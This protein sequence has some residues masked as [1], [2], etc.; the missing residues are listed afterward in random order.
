MLL[1]FQFYNFRSF[2]EPATLSLM[3]K[4]SDKELLDNVMAPELPGISKQRFLRAAAV[5][6]ANAAGKSNIIRS[7]FVLV[8]MIRHSHLEELGKE[9]PHDPF[10]LDSE[11]KEQ[12]TGYRVRFVSEGVRYHYDLIHDLERVLEE[13]LSAFPK[14]SEQ[15]WLDRYWD[16]ESKRYHYEETPESSPI[17]L[18]DKALKGIKGNTLYM[19]YVAN[20]QFQEAIEPVYT[21][22]RDVVDVKNLAE[23]SYTYLRMNDTIRYA[24]NNHHEK[25]EELLKRADFGVKSLVLDQ[26]DLSDEELNRYPEEDDPSKGVRKMVELELT[27]GSTNGEEVLFEMKNESTGTLRMLSLAG[28]W[29]EMIERGKV[30]FLDELETSLHPLLVR[31]LVAMVLDPEI[32]RSGAQLVVATHDPLLLDMSLFRRDQVWFTEKNGLGEST[33]YPLTDFKP[34]VRDS[35]IRGYLSGRYGAIPFIP[36]RLVEA[37]AKK[38]IISAET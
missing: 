14:G 25:V 27:H 8:K 5:Y 36:Q 6:G 30:M 31:E 21:W 15:V 34:T 37:D 2:K 18:K 20:V 17:L 32:N 26:R 35:L 1:D 7:M 12:P 3:A 23:S 11:S 38:E 22:F 9:M 24:V 29:L 13:R 10:L 4:L 28:P 19:S 33:L 16:E